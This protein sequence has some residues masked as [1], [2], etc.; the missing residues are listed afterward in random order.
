VIRRRLAAGIALGA[1]AVACASQPAPPT[2]RLADGR[3]AMGTVLEITLHGPDPA[4]LSR[5]RDR[6]FDLALRLD[7]LMSSYRDSSDVSR[8]AAAAGM[9][10]PIHPDVAE[11][12]RA[13][14]RFTQLTRGSFD[15]TIGPLVSLWTLAAERDR[16]PD[17]AEIAAAR[18]V[19]GPARLSLVEDGRAVL[20]PGA[21][22]ELGGVAKGFALDRM[23]PVLREEGVTGALLSF[24]QSS[25][26]AVG[27]PPDA[28]GW[29]LLARAPD[30]GFAGL[31]TLRDRA[32][33]VSGSFGTSSEIGGRRFGHVIDP[34]SGWPLTRS[35]E[36]IVV[37]R[38]AAL[39]EALSKALLVLGSEEG[40]P[41]VES[42]PGCQGLLLSAD[43]A[44][45]A[46]R[47]FDAE[48]HFEALPGDAG[49]PP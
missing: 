39:A 34:R 46:T 17:D 28:P 27:T 29:T 13:S 19:S 1:S 44:H 43:G 20:A 16:V 24:G 47:G 37:C 3:Y 41:V 18:A 7:A 38:D 15:V 45:R 12:L 33:S 48:V 40:A 30:G 25:A 4:A 35:A 26:W 31:L 11:L 49:G 36:A 5:A 14:L 32:L 23:L 6:V 42:Q 2:H 10:V 9:A 22:I 21:R 8:L